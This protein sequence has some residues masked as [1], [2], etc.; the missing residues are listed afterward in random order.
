MNDYAMNKEIQEAID[1]GERA[2]HSLRTAQSKL[3]SARSWGLWDMFGGGS[4]SGLIKHSRI[5]EASRYIEDAKRDLLRFEKELRDI[6]TPMNLNIDM[7]GFLTFADFFFDGFIA[8]YI[9]QSKIA[10]AREQVDKAIQVVES[11]LRNLRQQLYN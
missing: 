8:D 2:L 1:A 3:K 5:S 11:L 6:S 10:E 4:L 9:V 7:N